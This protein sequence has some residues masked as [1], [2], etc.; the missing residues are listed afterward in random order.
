MKG[1]GLKEWEKDY[2]FMLLLLLPVGGI[3]SVLFGFFSYTD[4]LVAI[5]CSVS[6]MGKLI[7]QELSK[8]CRLLCLFVVIIELVGV[9]SSIFS[10]IHRSLFQM[11]MDAFLVIKPYSIFLFFCSISIDNKTLVVKKLNYAA[12][13]LLILL[14]FLALLSQVVDIGMTIHTDTVFGIKINVFGFIFNNGIQTVWLILGCFI[15]ICFN[16]KEKVLLNIY[17][18]I[19]L[20]S[21]LCVFGGFGAVLISLSIVFFYLFRENRE[22]KKIKIWQFVPLAL[23]LF[24]VAFSDIKGYLFNQTAPRALL[25]KYGFETA[26]N[27]FPLGSGFAT[28]GSEMAARYYSPLYVKYKFNSIWSLSA[29]NVGVNSTLK[30]VYAGMIMGQFGFIG[31]I[32]FAL[33][34]YSMFRTLN[35]TIT[36]NRVKA[37]SLAAFFTICVTMMVSANSTTLIGPFVFALLGLCANSGINKQLEKGSLNEG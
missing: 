21:L 5:L 30:D 22:K 4:E 24:F 15:I 23:I 1:Q 37:I 10:N 35:G 31:F 13:I 14:F 25:I 33:I 18:V 3:L 28:Y 17:F 32:I 2:A 16:E 7:K 20:I 36:N 29:E 34:L 8:E 11:I 26:K 9:I 6:I 19:Y 27:Y 12:R